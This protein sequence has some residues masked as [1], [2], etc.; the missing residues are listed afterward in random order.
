MPGPKPAAFTVAI[1]EEVASG[2]AVPF[3][4]ETLSHVPPLVATVKSTA[5]D[6]PLFTMTGC[7]LGGVLPWT[8]ENVSAD[9]P[10]DSVVLCPGP[11]VVTLPE[12]V[13]VKVAAVS[14]IGT[15]V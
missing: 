1:T 11:V 4:G 14:E 9:G 13:K 3:A 10:T 15:P 12:P 7:E 5:C 2:W 6:V 8:N